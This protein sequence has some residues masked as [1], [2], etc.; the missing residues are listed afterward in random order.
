MSLQRRQSR[1]ELHCTGITQGAP[2]EVALSGPL[3]SF[4]AK[5]GGP[6]ALASYLLSGAEDAM[7]NAGCEIATF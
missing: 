2:I 4:A 1:V 7:D 6:D 5:A 3:G